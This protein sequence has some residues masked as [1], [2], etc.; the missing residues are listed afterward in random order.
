M[1]CRGS[2]AKPRSSLAKPGWVRDPRALQAD[3]RAR[4]AFFCVHPVSRGTQIA[5][6][7][8]SRLQEF[9]ETPQG[10]WWLRRSS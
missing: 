9:M 2:A 3:C 7:R 5:F 4:I 1:R 10:Y 6:S 8:V